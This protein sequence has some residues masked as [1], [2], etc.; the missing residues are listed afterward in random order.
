MK[1]QCTYFLFN[2]RLGAE[3]VLHYSLRFIIASLNES[4]QPQHCVKHLVVIVPANCNQA[5]FQMC[6]R[7]D[8]CLNE[9]L[10]RLASYARN[11]AQWH[12]IYRIGKSLNTDDGRNEVCKC[13]RIVKCPVRLDVISLHFAH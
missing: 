6:F 4:L 1:K 3:R 10:L 13:N 8:A 7:V 9:L 11:R 2:F 12:A 5:L